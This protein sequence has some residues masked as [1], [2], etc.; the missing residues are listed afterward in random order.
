MRE[1]KGGRD[2]KNDKVKARH[3]FDVNA[4]DKKRNMKCFYYCT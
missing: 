3:T 1:E 2:F 4:N